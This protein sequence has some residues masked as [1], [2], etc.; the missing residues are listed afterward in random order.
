MDISVEGQFAIMSGSV[1]RTDCDSLGF[2]LMKNDIKVLVLKDSGG[3]DA[4][5]GHCVGALVRQR[6]IS[7]VIRGR[8]A[9]APGSRSMPPPSIVP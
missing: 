6:G 4:G 3:G 2:I 5:A 1:L 7:T 9:S 8:C